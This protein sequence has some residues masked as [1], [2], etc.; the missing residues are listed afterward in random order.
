MESVVSKA[1]GKLVHDPGPAENGKEMETDG[2]A[3]FRVA[4]GKR[5]DNAETVKHHKVRMVRW[6][7]YQV[8]E[9]VVEMV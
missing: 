4:M 9:R 1:R 5:R 2:Q 6:D 7:T 3:R 8:C